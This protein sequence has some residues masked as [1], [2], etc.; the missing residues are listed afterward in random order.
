VIPEGYPSGLMQHI[1]VW[2]DGVLNLYARVCIEQEARQAAVF[3]YKVQV[4]SSLKYCPMLMLRLGVDPELCKFRFGRAHV[5]TYIR[6]QYSLTSWRTL[7][8]GLPNVCFT[9][10]HV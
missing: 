1:Y 4:E 8:H 7:A 6:L 5:T 9:F 10:E 2:C 3:L